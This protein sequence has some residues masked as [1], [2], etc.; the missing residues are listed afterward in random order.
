MALSRDGKWVATVGAEGRP[1]SERVKVWDAATGRI[2]A[3]IPGLSCV[4]FSADS[5]WL[6]ADDRTCY[7]FYRAGSWAPVSSVG[8][9]AEKTGDRGEMRIAFHP[10]DSIAAIL[11][12]DRSTVRLVDARTGRVL[13]SIE[14][15]NESQ[16]HRL[17]FSPGGRFL[18]VS[19]NSQKVDLWDLSLI[20]RRLQD[21]DLAAGFPE[22]FD[23]E[24]PAGDQHDISRLEVKGADPAGLRLLAVRHTLREAASAIQVFLDPGITDA[25]E[26]SSRA[27]LWYRLGQWRTSAADFRVALERD[28]NSAFAANNLAWCLAVLPG[29]GDADEAVRWARK[30]VDLEPHPNYRNTLGAAL[31]RA[32]HFAEAVVELERNIAARS[33]AS[34]YDWVFLAMC[35]QRLGQAASARLALAYAKQSE[36]RVN[37]TNPGQN[38]ELH[39]LVQEAQSLLN[40]SLPE[41]PSN[42]FDR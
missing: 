22:I 37:Q 26:L 27:I 31:Y 41:I 5:Q 29:R 38:A 32:G 36:L 17:V 8:Y 10:V 12:G 11:G 21:L 19:H 25:E 4:A 16:V 24:T 9:E 15:P 34:G 14:G 23:G 42:V 7:R 1:G 33:A 28:P 18:A 20:H 35:R 40:A 13:A 2:N 3:E 39:T 30:A 6:G